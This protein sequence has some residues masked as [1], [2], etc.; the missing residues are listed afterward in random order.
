MNTFTRR[1]EFREKISKYFSVADIKSYF[2]YTRWQ[3]FVVSLRK[4]AD[5]VGTPEDRFS[6]D[7]VQLVVSCVNFGIR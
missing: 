4:H 5:L 3:C 7:A 6:R 1:T 2:C